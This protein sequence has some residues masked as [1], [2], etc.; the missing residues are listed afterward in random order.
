MRVMN[1]R[2]LIWI[3]SQ[4]PIRARQDAGFVDGLFKE[5]SEGCGCGVAMWSSHLGRAN[6][7]LR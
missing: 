5:F 4:L 6:G 7:L 3:Q 2:P 1:N